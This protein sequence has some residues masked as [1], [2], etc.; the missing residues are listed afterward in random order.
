M[1]KK[2]LETLKQTDVEK[3]SGGQLQRVAIARTLYFEKEICVFDE[4]TSALDLQAEDK[5]VNHLNEI[6]KDKIII[7]VSHRMNAMKYCDK[8]YE[9]KNGQLI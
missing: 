2:I 6:K 4:F 9:L 5:I 3:L 8:I 7:I 1:K